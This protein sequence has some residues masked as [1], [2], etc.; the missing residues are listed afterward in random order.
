[1]QA[2]L[3]VAEDTDCESQ[4]EQ[5]YRKLQQP[6]HRKKTTHTLYYVGLGGKDV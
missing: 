6:R 3:Q 5:I 2:C 4:P 1:L